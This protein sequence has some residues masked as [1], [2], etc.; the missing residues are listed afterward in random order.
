[1]RSVNV[2]DFGAVGDGVTM[3]TAAIQ[4]AIDHCT[5]GGGGRVILSGG[6]FLTGRIDLKDGVDLHI[7]RDAVLLGSADG[8]DFPEIES[9]V[10]DVR[11]A[12]RFNRRCMIYAEGARDIAITGRGVIDCQGKNY[13]MPLLGS[14]PEETM[15]LYAEKHFPEGA[16]GDA[17]WPFVRK[18]FPE[19]FEDAGSRGLTEK[20][21]ALCSLS[22]AR[23]V[24]FMKCENVLV[25][26]VTMRDQPSGWSYW[27]C[28]CENVHFHRAVIRASV[29][30]PNN[31]GIHIN[32]CRNVTVSDCNIACGDDGIVL[33]AYSAPLGKPVPC[34]K[35]TVTNCNITSHSGGFRIG[36]YDD[37]VIRDCAISNITITDTTVGVDIVLPDTPKDHRGSDQGIED[38]L[39]ENL[40][41]SNIVM[42]RIFYEPV[43]ILIGDGCRCAGVRDLFFTGVRARAVHMPS[44]IGRRDCPVKNLSFDLCRFT[45]IPRSA[46]PDEAA[47]PHCDRPYSLSPYFKHVEGLT[48]NG[49]TF[50]VGE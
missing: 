8:R 1:M 10:W 48:M 4:A 32:C 31:D 11:Y 35:V 46:I 5:A 17:L 16:E 14:T 42:D 15:K 33:R 3:D 9:E 12:P 41:F 28:G 43:R 39:I 22:P 29:L 2:Q 38:T 20:Q 25:E 44:V 7:E 6:T 40:S 37:G 26:D 49:T 47:G 18:P 23:V 50:T 30:Y 19:G 24:L 21:R 34:E 45:S 27:V 13:I 36:W